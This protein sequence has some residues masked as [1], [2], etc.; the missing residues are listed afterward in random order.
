MNDHLVPTP[1]VDKNGVSSS[2]MKKQTEHKQP[3]IL[4]WLNPVGAVRRRAECKNLAMETDEILCRIDERDHEDAERG[5]GLPDVFMNSTDVDFL[6]KALV[7]AELV[8]NKDANQ[9]RFF[10]GQDELRSILSRFLREEIDTTVELNAIVAHRDWLASWDNDRF[11]T[12][13]TFTLREVI[14]PHFPKSI[15]QDGS[16]K[17]VDAHCVAYVH[18]REVS[19]YNPY[20]EDHA[21]MKAVDAHPDEVERVLKFIDVQGSEAFNDEAFAEYK[22]VPPAV[23]DGWL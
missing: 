5:V 9:S 16:I 7:A 14:R 4:R 12:D 18:F 3:S 6:R 19:P 21:A 15:Q 17:N 13:F 10:N 8:T 23:A 11:L 2:R 1:I 20:H 22:L